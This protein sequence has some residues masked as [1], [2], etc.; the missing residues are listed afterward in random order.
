MYKCPSGF[1]NTNNEQQIY[2]IQPLLFQLFME[3][4]LLLSSNFHFLLRLHYR[5]KVYAK[6]AIQ[7]R[8]GDI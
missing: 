8:V 6:G 7:L 5:E 3:L 1:F 2:I 4:F